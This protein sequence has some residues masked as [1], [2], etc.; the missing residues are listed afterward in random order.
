MSTLTFSR[1]VLQ[2]DGCKARH[3][4]P[5]G[6]NSAHE[7]RIAAY[8]D[9][10]RYPSMVRADGTIGT[11]TSDVCPACMPTW[12]PRRWRERDKSRRLRN[13]EAPSAEPGT[14]S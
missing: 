14:T 5:D 11:R 6:H 10:W 7:A 1:Y 3:G 2:C 9:G 4:E 13:A 12:M 8:I